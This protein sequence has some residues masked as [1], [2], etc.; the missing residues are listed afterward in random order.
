MTADSLGGLCYGD[1]RPVQGV[2][3]PQAGPLAALYHSDPAANFAVLQR[4]LVPTQQP[5]IQNICCCVYGAV[6][7]CC[8]FDGIVFMFIV[9]ICHAEQSRHRSK[10]FI[11]FLVF[12]F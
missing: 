2:V 1:G 9:T 11:L 10:R 5:Q 3:H 4:T 12:P 7:M 8:G 6:F